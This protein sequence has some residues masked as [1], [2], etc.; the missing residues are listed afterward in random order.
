MT[1]RS[2]SVEALGFVISW[3]SVTLALYSSW[4]LSNFLDGRSFSVTKSLAWK[5]Q[6]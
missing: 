2:F 5:T 6:A 1:N 3:G 4:R